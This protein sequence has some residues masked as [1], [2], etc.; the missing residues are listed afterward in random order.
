[1]NAALSGPRLGCPK[2]DPELVAVAKRQFADDQ[3]QLNS[4][5]VKSGQRKYRFGLELIRETLAAIPGHC[6][7]NSGHVSQEAAAAPFAYL[8]D[9]SPEPLCWGSEGQQVAIYCSSICSLRIT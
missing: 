1:M 7:F 9:E 6:L 4:L 2:N 8:L 5:A 3:R